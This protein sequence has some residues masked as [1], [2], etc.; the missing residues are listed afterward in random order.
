MIPETAPFLG[1]HGENID[2]LTDTNYKI[3]AKDMEMLLKRLGI[4]HIVNEP[5]PEIPSSA[6]IKADDYAFSEVIFHGGTTIF[7]DCTNAR[8]CCKA[9]ETAHFSKSYIDKFKLSYN[10]G[11]MQ[12][13]A[14]E[15]LQTWITRVKE[16]DADLKAVGETLG[17]EKVA[18]KLLMGLTDRYKAVSTLVFTGINTNNPLT[19]DSAVASLMAYEKREKS[20]LPTQVPG[21]SYDRQ[22]AAELGPRH[23]EIY[24]HVLYVQSK[25]WYLL[26]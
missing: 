18:Y 22:H 6:W 16:A 20:Y 15:T 10:F 12:M 11:E 7:R 13:G 4:W 1:N 23:Y 3:W 19:V 9:L 24:P 5:K 14:T 17:D 8:E 21:A 2:K 25:I 26:G